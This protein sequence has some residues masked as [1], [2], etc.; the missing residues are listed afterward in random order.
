[1][2]L[3]EARMKQLD[4]FSECEPSYSTVKKTGIVWKLFTDGASRDNPGRSGAGVYLAKDDQP[5]FKKGFYLGRKTNNQ[6]E[7]LALLVGIFYAKK[8]M[9]ENDTLFIFADSELLIKQMK[10]EYKV[11]NPD[12]KI[13]YDIA[14]DW[15]ESLNYSVCHVR[16]EFNT[17]ADEMA[18]LGID[19]KLH[20]TQ[21]FLHALERH[22][23]HL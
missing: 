12:L 6:A 2:F 15:L 21:E 16:R 20:P 3:K 23:V 22:N 7:Y 11:K 5:V 18:N 13:L 19:Q 1:M 4:I 8:H 9:E 14:R 17:V 10:G